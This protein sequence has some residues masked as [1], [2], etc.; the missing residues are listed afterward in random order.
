MYTLVAAGIGILIGSYIHYSK[1]KKPRLARFIGGVTNAI[2][3]IAAGILTYYQPNIFDNPLVFLM[4][5]L[6]ISIINYF[7]NEAYRK[8]NNL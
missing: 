4:P 8:R 6:V 1:D 5:I 2:Y 3:L 7:A